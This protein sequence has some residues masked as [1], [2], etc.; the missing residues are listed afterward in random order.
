MTSSFLQE[1]LQQTKEIKQAPY[2]PIQI[3]V[4][5]LFATYHKKYKQN[6]K[7]RQRRYMMLFL[8]LRY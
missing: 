2:Q 8:L 5:T 7:K 6:K 4:P 1:V 3:L